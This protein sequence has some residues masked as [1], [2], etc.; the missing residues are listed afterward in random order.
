MPTDPATD[1]LYP[2]TPAEADFIRRRVLLPLPVDVFAG[3]LPTLDPRV[4]VVGAYVD[5]V[6]DAI[7]LKL[8]DPLA[9]PVEPGTEAPY[10]LLD[11]V[12]L[13]DVD[14]LIPDTPATDEEVVQY[15][16]KDPAVDD[17]LA[18]LTRGANGDGDT[19]LLVAHVLNATVRSGL[20]IVDANILRDVAGDYCPAHPDGNGVVLDGCSHCSVTE[21]QRLQHPA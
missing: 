5:H 14:E 15:I 12:R 7:V 8:L 11:D 10:V 9:D 2:D 19:R 6:H 17:M 3:G 16:L 20:T 18:E 21:A 4:V 13:G 1:D